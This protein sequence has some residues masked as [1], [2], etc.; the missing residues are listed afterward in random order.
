[1]NLVTD[2]GEMPAERQHMCSDFIRTI[3][4]VI[5]KNC[6]ALLP[7]PGEDRHLPRLGC[8]HLE[9][10]AGREAGSMGCYSGGDYPF[11]HNEIIWSQVML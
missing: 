6:L 10:K 9:C 4:S 11:A 8:S 7:L 1:M 5:E 3:S 2:A